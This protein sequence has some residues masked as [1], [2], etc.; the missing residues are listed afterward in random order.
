MQLLADSTAIKKD[1]AMAY[2]NIFRRNI[3]TANGATEKD[4]G[5]GYTDIRKN[6]GDRKGATICVFLHKWIKKIGRYYQIFQA[7]TSC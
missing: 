4:D 1:E 3:V 5:M 6:T 2:M 7:V